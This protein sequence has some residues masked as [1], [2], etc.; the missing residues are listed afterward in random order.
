VRV[1]EEVFRPDDL[2][3]EVER[4]V[5]NED[6]AEHGP[7]GLEIVRQGTLGGSNDVRHERGGGPI[8][9]CQLPTPNSQLPNDEA[10]A[11][12][13]RKREAFKITTSLQAR[14]DLGSWELVVGS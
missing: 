10:K 1:A 8:L 2:D 6:G 5:V 11:P 4:F 12:S 9:A 13:P 7:F 3:G 14:R